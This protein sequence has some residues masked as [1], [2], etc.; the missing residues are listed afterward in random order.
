[1]ESIMAKKTSRPKQIYQLEIW[2]AEIEPRIWRKFEVPSDIRL[3]KLH[4]VIQAVMGWTDSHLHSF[5]AGE[6]EYGMPDLDEDMYDN[7]MMDETRAH[8]TDLV[9][10][11]KDRFVYTYDYGDNWEHIIELVE[12]KEPQSGIKYPVCL[13]GERACPP[14]DCGGPWSYPDFVKTMQ[15][16]NTKQRREFIEWLGYEFDPEEFDIEEVNKVLRGI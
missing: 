2:L 12:I 8:L 9:T 13:A 15:G 10:R 16:K 5:S 1:M 7:G 6:D 14:E 4:G 11:P 3:D